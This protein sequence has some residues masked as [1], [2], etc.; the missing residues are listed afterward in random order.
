MRRLYAGGRTPPRGRPLYTAPA[1]QS[2]QH[3][4]KGLSWH[5]EPTRIRS[6]GSCCSTASLRHRIT[7]RS[8]RKLPSLSPL[9]PR[10]YS[11]LRH[12]LESFAEKQNYSFPNSIAEEC[13]VQSHHA[14]FLNCTHEHPVFLDPPEDV[15]LAL[16][17]T[18]ICLIPFLV[19]LVVW[20][21]KD[22][23]MQS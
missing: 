19:T 1:G 18:P 16:I 13:I 7:P 5:G 17:V 11:D 3:C 6:C 10:P 23:K 12:C 2:S 9:P 4:G 22:G 8:R 20:R 21:S 15:L 14:Y